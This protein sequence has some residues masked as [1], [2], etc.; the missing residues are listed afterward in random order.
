MGVI[1]GLIII[2]IVYQS[3]IAVTGRSESDELINLRSERNSGWVLAIALFWLVGHIVAESAV[4]VSGPMGTV[5]VAVWI[6]LTL[7]VAEFAKLLSQVW[8]Y[9]LD[10]R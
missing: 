5:L 8:Y 1:V 9:W 10:A 7:T 2:E 6:L 3:L 4:D